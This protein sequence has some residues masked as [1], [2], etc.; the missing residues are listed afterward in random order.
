MTN[1][2]VI[3]ILSL[4]LTLLQRMGASLHSLLEK[5][6]FPYQLSQFPV[7]PVTTLPLLGSPLHYPRLDHYSTEGNRHLHQVDKFHRTKTMTL[8]TPQLKTHSI[9]ISRRSTVSLS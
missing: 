4:H 7:V 2:P 1:T 5:P 3:A 6:C 8:S 9:R